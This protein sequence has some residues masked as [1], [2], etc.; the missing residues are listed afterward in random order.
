MDVEH[1]DARAEE[2]FEVLVL[3]DDSDLDVLV[4]GVFEDALGDG[5]DDVVGFGALVGED[6][7]AE[8]AGHLEDA[9]DLWGE[10]F[11]RG[12]ARCFVLGVELVSEGGAWGVGGDDDVV[13]VELVEELDEHGGEGEDGVGGFAGDG[14][15]HAAADGVVGAEDLGVAVDEV[16]GLGGGGVGGGHGRGLVVV[17]YGSSFRSLVDPL[18]YGRGS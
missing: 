10:V 11:R 18:P 5:G 12:F 6:G 15:G 16:E 4:V 7:D 9:F 8:Q 14:R 13:G 2:L 3:G 1:G 17:V